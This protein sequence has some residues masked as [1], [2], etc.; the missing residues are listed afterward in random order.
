LRKPGPAASAPGSKNP[1]PAGEAAFPVIVTVVE[2]DPEGTGPEAEA[3]SAGGGAISF[4]ART[5]YVFVP[6]QYS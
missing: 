5:P 3:G 2:E 6:L 4:T 1:E